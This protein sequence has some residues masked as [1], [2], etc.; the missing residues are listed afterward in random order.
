MRRGVA[1]RRIRTK[2]L[3]DT[4]VQWLR[5]YASGLITTVD[6][7]LIQVPLTPATLCL[8][9]SSEVLLR[10]TFKEVSDGVLEYCVS[11]NKW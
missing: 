3:I 4:F 5:L 2:V 8:L 9:L 11:Q 1:A 7:G 10:L 6:A